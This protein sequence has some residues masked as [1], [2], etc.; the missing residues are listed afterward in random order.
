MRRYL[1]ALEAAQPIGG[2]IAYAGP[3][4]FDQP[5]N[6][7]APYPPGQLQAYRLRLARQGWLLCDGGSV[8][9]ARYPRLFRAIGFIYGQGQ[10]AQGNIQP[11]Y[12]QL[13]DYRGRVLRGVSGGA[14]DPLGLENAQQ[15]RDPDASSRSEQGPG[16]WSGNAVGS[17]QY[18]ALQEHEH[19]YEKASSPSRG[20]QQGAQDFSQNAMADT[21][22]IKNARV[23]EETRMKNQYVHFLIRAF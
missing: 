21:E 2:V 5:R 22:K 8:A 16:G 17:L 9:I 23:S 19:Q 10:D 11:G 6:A 3:V 20:G 7:Q 1:S 12:F 18:D 4:A 13:P 15:P 14:T